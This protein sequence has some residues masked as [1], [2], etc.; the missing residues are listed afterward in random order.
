MASA[1]PETLEQQLHRRE[2]ELAAIRRITA[3]NTIFLGIHLQR[4]FRP[5]RIVLQRRQTRPVFARQRAISK[6]RQGFQKIA[7]GK[8]VRERHPG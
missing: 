3:A 2:R 1:S 6:P 5:I 8:R 4:I 7:P